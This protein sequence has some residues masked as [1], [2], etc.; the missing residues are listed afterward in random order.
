LIAAN[1]LI[2]SYFEASNDGVNY[3]VIGNVDSTVHTGWNI[4]PFAL[5]TNYRYIRFVSNQ[6]SKCELAEL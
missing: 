3:V 5:S 6:V 1:Y 2:G 4:M